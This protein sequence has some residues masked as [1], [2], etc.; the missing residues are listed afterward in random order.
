ME[1]EAEIIT[2]DEEA[3]MTAVE[4][5]SIRDLVGAEVDI[6]VATAHRYPRKIQQF[7]DDMRAWACVD[8]ETA[9]SCYYQLRRG[10]KNIQGPSVRLAEIAATCYGN[11]RHG[12]DI[13]DT[14]RK[15]VTARGFAWDLQRNVATSCQVKRRITDS[16]GQTYNDDM[17]GVT[18][19]AA[20]SIALRNAVFD[21]VPFAL[22]K[23]TYVECIQ[24]ALGKD[25]S[26][27]DRIESAL[28]WYIKQGATAEA[29]F[30]SIDRKGREDIT[31][32]DL[33][34]LRGQAT[35]VQERQIT[36]EDALRPPDSDDSG[37]RVRTIT[38]PKGA[39]KP[40]PE[41][42]PE[43]KQEAK[44]DP[45]PEPAS[46]PEPKAAPEPESAKQDASSEVTSADI[47]GPPEDE[48]PA[49]SKSKGK[50]KK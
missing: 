33:V 13:I 5:Q 39:P 40:D 21:V 7:R 17:I 45:K 47:S 1:V 20:G 42:K 31:V 24:V 32:D 44:P 15:F 30:A 43:P 3:K 6:Q 22:I 9:Q 23:P 4:P 12:F 19:N 46:S 16:R 29:V 10:R 18:S 14:D 11:F 35:A 25:M 36:L 48:E 49:P 27:N 26:H 2:K 8:Q 37:K 38:I 41:P 28:T 50:R 34:F